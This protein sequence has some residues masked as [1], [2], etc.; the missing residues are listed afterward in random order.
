M[1]FLNGKI[2]KPIFKL[3]SILIY[4][5]FITLID[6]YSYGII[7]QQKI[8]KENY[9]HPVWSWVF[10]ESANES[11]GEHIVVTHYRVIQKSLEIIGALIIFYYCGFWSFLGILISHYL[12]SYDLLFYIVLN[13]TYLFNEFQ[14]Q[15]PPYWLQNWYQI[16]YFVLK[17]FNPLTF[18]ICG[19][20]GIVI[21]LCSGIFHL[22]SQN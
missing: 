8:K 6:V 1:K 9:S 11:N 22:K 2:R 16:G 19:F 13:Q 7:Y 5:I 18:W 15:Y 12:L 14:F 21:A 4:I 3:V 10:K 17:P 20:G